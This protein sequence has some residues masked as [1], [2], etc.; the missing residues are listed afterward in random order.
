MKGEDG[1]E[2]TAAGKRIIESKRKKT[3]GNEWMREQSRDCWEEGKSPSQWVPQHFTHCVFNQIHKHTRT[4]MCNWKTY[5][6]EGRAVKLSGNT[7][8][9]GEHFPRGAIN[10][11][12]RSGGLAESMCAGA[13]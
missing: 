2:E 7:K 11:S 8:K 4:S 10:I 13:L 9:G 3:D 5:L 1:E 12:I 6:S